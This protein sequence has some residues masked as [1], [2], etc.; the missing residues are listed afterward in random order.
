MS[1]TY[2][3]RV[4]DDGRFT[5]RTDDYNLA[6]C[7]AIDL[8]LSSGLRQ[9]YVRDLSVGRNVAYFRDGTPQWMTEGY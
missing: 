7:A 1:E 4:G 2:G 3:V 8:S 5:T 9:A 6:V